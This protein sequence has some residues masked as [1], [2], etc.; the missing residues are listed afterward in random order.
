[1]GE[2]EPG[3]ACFNTI[4]PKRRWAAKRGGTETSPAQFFLSSTHPQSRESLAKARRGPTLIP[5]GIPAG[6]H[7]G[8]QMHGPR[9]RTH[10]CTES[11]SESPS[12]TNMRD[13]DRPAHMCRKFCT[14][15]CPRLLV[16]ISGF[17]ERW[18][19]LKT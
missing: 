15:L 4:N 2:V 1:M 14:Q 12:P 3:R 5:G 13:S 19:T 11:Q 10:V 16:A 6:L 17:L 9:Q 18:V 7:T 8:A